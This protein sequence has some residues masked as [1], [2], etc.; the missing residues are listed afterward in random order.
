LS[1]FSIDKIERVDLGNPVFPQP[2]ITHNCCQKGIRVSEQKAQKWD[3]LTEA[4]SSEDGIDGSCRALA[5]TIPFSAWVLQQNAEAGLPL[6]YRNDDGVDASTLPPIPQPGQV[7]CPGF[8][9][10]FV[11]N[12][13]ECR[14]QQ[15][16]AWHSILAAPVGAAGESR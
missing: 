7:F 9:Q 16:E 14:Y 11:A 6:V 15:V 5:C 12:R 1:G 2:P 13:P 4:W 8:F 10:H 3:F